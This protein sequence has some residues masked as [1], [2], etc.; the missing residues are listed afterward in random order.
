M[1]N[2]QCVWKGKGAMKWVVWNYTQVPNS[3]MIIFILTS[4]GG[5]ERGAQPGG[6][7]MQKLPLDN[8]SLIRS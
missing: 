7:L 2:I 6:N 4:W 8:E 3:Q 1:E 5:A